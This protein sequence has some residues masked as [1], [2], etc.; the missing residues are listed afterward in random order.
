MDIMEPLD[1]PRNDYET[2]LKHTLYTYYQMDQEMG[3]FS[4]LQF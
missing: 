4:I 2:S 1:I 3:V